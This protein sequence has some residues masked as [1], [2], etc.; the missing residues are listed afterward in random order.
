MAEYSLKVVIVGDGTVGKTSLLISYTENRFPEEYQPSVFDNYTTSELF[1]GRHIVQLQ[2]WDTAGQSDYDRL[3]P[4][5]YPET[6]CFVM[7]YSTVSPATFDNIELKWYPE[8]RFYCPD[9]PI[10]LVATKI[11]LRTDEATV[12]K[13]RLRDQEPV[14]YEMGLKVKQAIRASDFIETSAKT[15][16]NLKKVFDACIRAVMHPSSRKS[17]VMAQRNKAKCTLC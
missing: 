12:K 17:N 2:L 6:N 11:D 3:R 16:Q 1:E 10:V 7:A 13:L 5:S 14:T 9:T 15:Q 4:L 8:V